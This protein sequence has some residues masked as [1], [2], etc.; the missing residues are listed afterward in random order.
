MKPINT[1]Y[2]F[3]VSDVN[4]KLYFTK[5]YDEHNAIINKLINEGLWYEW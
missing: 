1:D 4:N 5:T 3:F 2:Y